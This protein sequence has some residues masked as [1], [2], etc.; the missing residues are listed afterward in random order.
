MILEMN[1]LKGLSS[2]SA[3]KGYYTILWQNY[4]NLFFGFFFSCEKWFFWY[5]FKGSRTQKLIWKNAI[6]G[7]LY[8]FA[9]KN[10]KFYFSILWWK[11]VVGMI[12]G[13]APSRV[14]LAK[15]IKGILY[16]LMTKLQ[17]SVFG[18]FSCENGFWYYL[19]VRVR[20]S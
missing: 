20:K 17:K 4:E 10:E 3:L 11:F 16:H 2:H 9:K 1:A 15:C 19:R 5:Y 7:I 6:K 12:K 13:W 8:N 18:F 14:K